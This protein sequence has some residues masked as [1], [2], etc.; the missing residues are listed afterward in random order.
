VGSG[1][2][3]TGVAA[4]SV[5]DNAVTTGKILDANVTLAKLENVTAG[6]FIVGNGSNRPTSVVMSGDATLSNAG[7]LTIANNAITAGKLGVNS[8]TTNAILDLNVTTEKLANGAVTV[9]KM[10]ST[11]NIRTYLSLGTL[12]SVVFANVSANGVVMANGVVSNL[13]AVSGTVTAVSFE[14]SGAALTGVVAT[15]VTDNAVTTGKIVNGA[16]TVA[17]LEGLSSGVFIIGVDGTSTNNAKVSMSGDATLSNTGVVTIANDA[18]STAKIANNAITAGKL[19]V[20][21]VITNAILNGA[22]TVAKMDSASN[23]R[24]YLSLATTDSVVFAAANVSGTVTANAFV[25]SGAGLTALNATSLS[26]GTVDTARVSGAYGGITGVG[27]IATGVWNGTAIAVANGGT[28]ATDASG[29]RT[30]LGLVIGTNVQAYNAGL[31]SIAGLS[32]AADKMIYTTASDTYGVTDLSP[33][34]RYLLAATTSANMRTMLELGSN[35]TVY[36]AGVSVNGMVQAESVSVNGTVTANA[37]VGDGSLLTGITGTQYTASTGLQLNGTT[38]AIS[39]SVVTSNYSGGVTATSFTGSG[40]GLTNIPATGLSSAALQSIA[41]LTTDADKMIYTTAADTYAVTDLSLLA[42]SLLAAT[43]IPA[44]NT[45]L[46]L[47][48][49]SSPTFFGLVLNGSGLTVSVDSTALAGYAATFKN[50][51][52]N[53]TGLNSGGG[54]AIHLGVVTA[55]ADDEFVAFY[56]DAGGTPVKIGRITGNN[57]DANYT[58]LEHATPEALAFMNKKSVV[59]SSAGADYAEYIRKANP[60]KQYQAGE[61]VGI[62]NGEV[63]DSTSDVDRVMSVSAKPIIV[64][65]EPEENKEDYVLVAFVGQVFIQVKGPVKSGQYIVASDEKGVGVA[66]DRSV[67]TTRDIS[68]V[69]GQAWE[70]SSKKNHRLVKVGITPMDIPVPVDTET[71]TRLSK[72]EKE[73]EILR[74]QL[75]MLMKEVRSMKK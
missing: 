40:S 37:F 23:I 8:V 10:D 74:E 4:T 29:A 44:M 64:G 32:T 36:F 2:G 35:N 16:V 31:L 43:D 60:K 72:L 66:K 27:T 59:F 7:A 11:S 30:N 26:S 5:A 1:A 34:G 21:S 33:A 65:N 54:V 50:L 61:L 12:D 53:G 19:G 48:V 69:V 63:V 9:A 49:D 20:D 67:L 3:L 47:G 6:Q 28:G 62:K 71:N 73:N 55:G 51:Q 41:G 58:M 18:I 17:K 22:V 56:Q 42:R 46:E 15:S 45:V 70:T 57:S 13:V 25:G 38:F 24:T 75:N 68:R 52:A 39:S 14:G